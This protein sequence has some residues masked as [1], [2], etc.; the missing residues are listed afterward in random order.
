MIEGDLVLIV[1]AL[2]KGFDKDSLEGTLLWNVNKKVAV[3]MPNGMIFIGASYEVV[4]S[5]NEGEK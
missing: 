2:P 1:S 4:K 5:E 3:L